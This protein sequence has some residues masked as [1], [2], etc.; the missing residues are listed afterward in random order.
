MRLFASIQLEDNIKSVLTEAQKALRKGGYSGRFTD[1]SSLHLTLAFIGEYSSPDRVMDAMERVDFAAFPVRLSG[2]VG[3]FGDLL[4]AGTEHSAELEGLAKK[5]RHELAEEQIPFDKKK[6]NPHITLVRD[7][8]IG[9]GNSF[10][11]SDV[12]LE[13][14]EMIVRGISLMRTDFG[15]HGA[16]Y[17]EVGYVGCT[18]DLLG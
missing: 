2:Y 7:S 8:Y 9:R 12:Q 1:I 6:F 4:W 14:A 3:N 5:L 10:R 18:D 17:T 11:F 16:V 15:K 13:Q